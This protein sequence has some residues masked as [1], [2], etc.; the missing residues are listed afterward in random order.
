M[1]CL[2]LEVGIH[3]NVGWRLGAEEDEAQG[4]NSLVFTGLSELGF[5]TIPLIP[6]GELN[7]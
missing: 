4:G 1:K 7:N 5:A 6:D 2:I 3:S